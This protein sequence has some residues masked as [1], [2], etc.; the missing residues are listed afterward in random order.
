M[1]MMI[2]IRTCRKCGYMYSYNPSVGATHCPNCGGMGLLG[3]VI[4]GK[5]N[6]MPGDAIGDGDDDMSDSTKEQNDED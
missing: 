2:D 4:F 1:S 6:R 5:R 3:K